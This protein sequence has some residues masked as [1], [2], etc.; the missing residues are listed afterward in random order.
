[1]NPDGFMRMNVFNLFARNMID[2]N[3]LDNWSFYWMLGW[4]SMAS[5]CRRSW[6]QAKN[7]LVENPKI[8]VAIGSA[9]VCSA[10]VIWYYSMMTRAD[11]KCDINGHESSIPQGVPP[12]PADANID[13]TWKAAGPL[14]F[15]SFLTSTSRTGSPDYLR[16]VLDSSFACIS[17]DTTKVTIRGF[18]IFGQYWLLPRHYVVQ[19]WSGATT[20]TL[21][22]SKSYASP[23]FGSHVCQIDM[24]CVTLCPDEDFALV[25]L[26]VPPGPNLLPYLTKFPKGSRFEG[27]QAMIR[28]GQGAVLHPTGPVSLIETQ[29]SKLT[30]L[31]AF[32]SGKVYSIFEYK[33]IFETK[34]GDC[35]SPLVILEKGRTLIAGVHVGVRGLDETN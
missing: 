5:R 9:L 32:P 11:S 7:K 26:G 28:Q 19:H 34:N 21:T 23:N 1:M 31:N 16:S 25:R 17:I 29:I 24:K 20:L 35:G 10:F 8:V 4:D 33:S 14:T 6:I 22:R 27:L 15:T 30:E 3:W 18:N 2:F 13:N 12:P